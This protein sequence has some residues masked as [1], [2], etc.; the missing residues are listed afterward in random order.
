MNKQYTLPAPTIAVE[1]KRSHETSPAGLRDC[2]T[3]AAPRKLWRSPLHPVPQQRDHP[4]NTLVEQRRPKWPHRACDGSVTL[5]CVS[6]KAPLP[7]YQQLHSEFNPRIHC[8]SNVRFKQAEPTY[9]ALWSY[10][11][12]ISSRDSRKNSIEVMFH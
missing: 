1:R 5:Q 8:P 3:V 6:E 9:I 2:V 10:P 4:A 12:R 7:R 11:K